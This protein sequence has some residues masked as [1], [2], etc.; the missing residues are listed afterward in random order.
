MLLDDEMSS[1]WDRLSYCALACAAAVIAFTVGD[2]GLT[3]DE[4]LQ[5]IY[6]N[7]VIPR[8]RQIFLRA[9]FYQPRGGTFK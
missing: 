5:H 1:P 7:L 3:W 6:G 4:P 8:P 9:H 2:Y